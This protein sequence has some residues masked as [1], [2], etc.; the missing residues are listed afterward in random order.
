MLQNFLC[1]IQLNRKFIMPINVKIP[2]IIGI[3]TFISRINTTSESF[4]ES[5]I[6]M[7]QHFSF[8]ST[9]NFMSQLSYELSRGYETQHK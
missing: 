7:F 3:L 9:L 6:F 2:T 8:M 5:T 1:S 4:K